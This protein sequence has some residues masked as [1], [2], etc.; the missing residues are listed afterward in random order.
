MNKNLGIVLVLIGII[1]VVAIGG[2]FVMQMAPKTNVPAGTNT[3]TNTNGNTQPTVPAANTPSTNT[4]P[5]STAGTYNVEIKNFAFSPTSLTIK[6]GDS[7]VWTNQDSA[8]HKLASDTGSEIE[9]S[10]LA[11]GE[12][13]SHAFENT[14]TYDY[15]CS[16]HPS[17]KAKIIVE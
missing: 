12:T 9:S 4:P 7:V 2:Y 10:S 3:Q 5:A 8:N 14:G 6:K 17:M 15:H 1:I 13:Y 11:N 16:I